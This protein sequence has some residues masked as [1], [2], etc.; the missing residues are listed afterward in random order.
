MPPVT[1]QDQVMVGRQDGH[2]LP[3]RLPGQ[4]VEDVGFQQVQG[5]AL[6]VQ[7]GIQ[8]PGQHVGPVR[9]HSGTTD[10]GVKHPPNTGD[11]PL[12]PDP[13]SHRGDQMSTADQRRRQPIQVGHPADPGGGVGELVRR[14]RVLTDH[15]ELGVSCLPG[16][17]GA[18]KPAAKKPRPAGRVVERACCPG[19]QQLADGIRRGAVLENH[20]PGR[21]RGEVREPHRRKDL[22]RPSG[23][24]WVTGRLETT[25]RFRSTSIQEP[26][27]VN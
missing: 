3:D 19:A 6:L 24:V 23:G 20:E 18:L 4:R 25:V 8:Q 21:H 7:P 26:I 5:Q 14:D 9:G 27:L 13:S 2:A 22:L 17:H 12:H 10:P 11:G 16:G 1:V 15:H